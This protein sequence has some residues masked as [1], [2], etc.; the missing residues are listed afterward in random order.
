MLIRNW[1]RRIPS[2]SS[3]KEQYLK[4]FVT[5]VA[6]LVCFASVA[7]A[8][9]QKLRLS[10]GVAIR[11]AAEKNLGVRAELYNPAQFEAD[12]NR[13]RAIYDPL[14][15]IQTLYSDSTEP[16]PSSISS[17]S[18]S[19]PISSQGNSFQFNSSLSQLFWSGATASLFFNNYY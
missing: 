8:E 1:N 12:I 2:G 11:M 16:V 15:S 6:I 17:N 13:N 19:S 7:Y 3:G 10:L 14:L 5:C 4:Q 9:D 18:N